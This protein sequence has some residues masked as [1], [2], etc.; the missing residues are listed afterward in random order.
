MLDQEPRSPMGEWLNLDEAHAIKNL[1]SRTYHSMSTLKFQ[2][3]SYLMMTGRQ[4]GERWLCPSQYAPRPSN[5]QLPPPS[6]SVHPELI[7]RPWIPS[8][9]PQ[10]EIHPDARRL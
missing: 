4:Q 5:Q 1:E 6:G 9:L 7:Y 10:G 2:F 3:D 8:R